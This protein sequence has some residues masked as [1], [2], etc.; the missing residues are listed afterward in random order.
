MVTRES[1]R[2]QEEIDDL[3]TVQRELLEDSG[4]ANEAYPLAKAIAEHRV[5]GH[6][7][8]LFR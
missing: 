7:L 1:R 3:E 2:E 4:L 5:L 8:F 6:P